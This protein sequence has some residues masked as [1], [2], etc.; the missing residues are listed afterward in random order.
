M[1]LSIYRAAIQCATH[2]AP[3]GLNAPMECFSCST[4]DTTLRSAGVRGSASSRFYRHIARLERKTGESRYR[5]API[6]GAW[7]PSPMGWETQ[8]LRI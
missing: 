4:F 8:P 7:F 5:Y 6:A 2:V 1:I 3:L